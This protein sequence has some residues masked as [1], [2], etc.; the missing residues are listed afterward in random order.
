[1]RTSRPVLSVLFMPLMGVASC[2]PAEPFH[3]VRM[4]NL[5]ADVKDFQIRY[6]DVPLPFRS[7]PD[8]VFAAGAASHYLD[9]MPI[10][11]AAEVR[12]VTSDGAPHCVSIPIRKNVP[13]PSTFRGRVVFTIKE[14]RASV[15]VVDRSGKQISSTGSGD[16]TP[17]V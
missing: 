2:A 14:D 17:C 4:V 1:M 13:S 16:S 8:P 3:T 10:P 6:G 15:V 11:E 7:G 9:D 12:W 5:G